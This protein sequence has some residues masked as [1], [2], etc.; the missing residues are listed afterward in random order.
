MMIWS[1]DLQA[2]LAEEDEAMHEDVKG[3]SGHEN[4]PVS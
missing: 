1:K 3:M 4:T 2:H